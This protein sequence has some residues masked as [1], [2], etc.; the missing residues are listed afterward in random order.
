L[1]VE[2]VGASS[3]RWPVTL[4]TPDQSSV[5][6]SQNP[7]STSSERNCRPRERGRPYWPVKTCAQR[8]AHRAAIAPQRKPTCRFFI[9]LLLA[10]VL[11]NL[12]RLFVSQ[13]AGRG[14][15][16]ESLPSLRKAMTNRS[17]TVAKLSLRSTIC[18][19]LGADLIQPHYA[20]KP[21]LGRGNSRLRQGPCRTQTCVFAHSAATEWLDATL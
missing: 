1:V 3:P 2:V 5:R 6:G 15:R 16:P 18:D 8:V 19:N 7:C 10:V 12:L 21:R 20:L 4:G 13:S 9:R 11:R 17:F 14:A